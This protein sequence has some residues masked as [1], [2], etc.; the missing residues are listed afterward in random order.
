[1]LHRVLGNQAYG[2]F[3]QAKL[4]VGAPDDPFE[5]EADRVA[6]AV[7]RMPVPPAQTTAVETRPNGHPGANGT[8]RTR[9]SPKQTIPAVQR[10]TEEE[11][12]EEESASGTTESFNVPIQRQV[13]DE[14]E[15]ETIRTKAAS[16]LTP[17]VTPQV[18]AQINGMRGN[19]QQL[20]AVARSF[21]EPRFGYDFSNVQIHT[22]DRA[23]EVSRSLHARA[24]TIG[25]DIVFGAG[26]YHPDTET[27][28]RLLAHELTH[29]LQQQPDRAH[30]HVLTTS[31]PAPPASTSYSEE[32]VQ[33]QSAETGSPSSPM[34]PGMAFHTGFIPPVRTLHRPDA[35]NTLA[36]DDTEVQ[37]GGKIA[38]FDVKTRRL[39]IALFGEDIEDLLD[40]L[41]EAGDIADFEGVERILSQLI[42]LAWDQL[43]IS[44]QIAE[45]KIDPF[46]GQL[47]LAQIHRKNL[48]YA[49]LLLDFLYYGRLAYNTIDEAIVDIDAAS[50]T[51][52]DTLEYL[53][54][55]STSA[56]Q[57]QEI[58][59][60]AIQE[61]PEAFPETNVR[62]YEKAEQMLRDTADSFEKAFDDEV[63]ALVELEVEDIIPFFVWMMNERESLREA[64]RFLGLTSFMVE[65]G[66][67][68][69]K[70][71][72]NY[73]NPVTLE[74]K[75]GFS[76]DD[77]DL[78]INEIGEDQ[79][80]H[81]EELQH[82]LG[83]TIYPLLE[84]W[85]FYE[86]YDALAEQM[87]LFRIA[88]ETTLERLNRPGEPASVT[89]D[90]IRTY[91]GT[92]AG[93]SATEKG[94]DEF[95]RR[96]QDRLD[97]WVRGLD[98]DE[99]I[100]EGFA[101]YD[102]LGEIGTALKQLA[103]PETVAMIVGFIAFLIAIQF[104]PYA[105]LIVDIIL[106]AL[107]GIDIL[108]GLVIFG[109]YFDKASEARSF[110][111]L[112][113]AS[114][115]L[116]G[117]GEAILNLLLELFGLAASRAIQSFKRYRN[118]KRFENLDDVKPIVD[119]FA[120]KQPSRSK[121]LR[122]AFEK[123][124]RAE[125]DLKPWEKRLAPE[126][127][128]VLTKDPDLRRLY[129]E[130]DPDVRR[131]FTRCKSPCYIQLDPPP[132]VSEARRINRILD[133]VKYKG[134]AASDKAR[135]ETKLKDY[136][137]ARTDDLSQAISDIYNPGTSTNLEALLDFFAAGGRVLGRPS[138]ATAAALSRALVNAR[139]NTGITRGRTA[140]GALKG[141]TVG[142]ARSDIPQISGRI[143]EGASP[144]AG[145]KLPTGSEFKPPTTF[146][147]AQAHAEHVIVEIINKELKRAMAADPK[148]K[149]GDFKG[150]I[151][152]HVEQAVCSTCKAGLADPNAG[153][154]VLKQFSKK[155]PNITIIIT[156]EGTDEIVGLRN[157]I[158][159][160]R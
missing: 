87:K 53:D 19:G 20:D 81:K 101:L 136:L 30:R 147:S 25:S 90:L 113:M 32:T 109:T 2:Q 111:D 158:R 116:K 54:W 24:F 83:P 49:V 151:L 26:E 148:I 99:R 48:L 95:Y 138:S 41:Q 31:L 75:G 144:E 23:A 36:R 128:D 121:D 45:G 137:Q 142:V 106:I 60:A 134:L 125:A 52:E 50:V 110:R 16:G 91:S 96:I 133:D 114:Q 18:Q 160:L 145:G 22:N 8:V 107:G 1:M 6:D 153:A 78:I 85:F 143:F 15:E 80:A 140:S 159:I 3:I 21:F 132:T 66:Y 150:D 33:K 71:Y 17:A 77:I 47:L 146:G 70:I 86:Y 27:G 89:L 135:I 9:P 28:R 156:A 43:S 84:N 152:M 139:V 79:P 112:Y 55:Y 64:A 131:L 58:L 100:I 129:G 130:M 56:P 119:E 68:T 4:T 38:D 154:G 105:N 5:R 155:Y 72:L 67:S 29:T 7:M 73:F 141:G 35:Q 61:F 108:K 14:E 10:Q 120:G 92:S 34:N 74:T 12:E 94:F 63:S 126:V 115:G 104:I 69:R 40:E 37:E 102:V 118:V 44:E 127:Q 117:G 65:G 11:E 123:A 149:P 42:L 57:T 13:S 97:T 157:G 39:A 82:I 51:E 124:R 98:K 103:T 76:A 122:E 46:S 88:A 62:L 59:N 93:L